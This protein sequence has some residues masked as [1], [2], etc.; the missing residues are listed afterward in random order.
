[1]KDD[2]ISY[3]KSSSGD[4]IDNNSAPRKSNILKI[5]NLN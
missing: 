1:M 4:D 2:E 5:F 3:E